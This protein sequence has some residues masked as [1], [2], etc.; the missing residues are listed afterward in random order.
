MR[1][2]DFLSEAMSIHPFVI[3]KA[4]EDTRHNSLT[5]ANT[6]FTPGFVLD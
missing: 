3:L 2:I 5:F 1:V 4:C 6:L